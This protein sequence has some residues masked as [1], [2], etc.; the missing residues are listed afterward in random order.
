MNLENLNNFLANIKLSKTQLNKIVQSG[1]FLGRLLGPLLKTKL[2]LIGNVLKPLAK[3]VLIPLRLTAAASATDAAIHKKMF[4]SGFT[5]LIIS[6]EEMND[7]MKTVKSLEESQ[8][9]IKGVSETIKMRQKN[10][11]EGFLRFY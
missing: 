8:L 9:L 2:S 4:G 5:T 6:N 1:E 7:F 11:K 3:S 10:K